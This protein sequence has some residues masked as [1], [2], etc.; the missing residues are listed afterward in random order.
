[1]PSV[2]APHRTSPSSPL[3]R[4][5]NGEF[6]FNEPEDATLFFRGLEENRQMQ[7]P[8][9]LFRSAL[10]NARETANGNDN[11]MDYETDPFRHISDDEDDNDDM[12][13]ETE[14]EM[15]TQAG[16]AA[17][18]SRGRLLDVHSPRVVLTQRRP[19][20]APPLLRQNTS[21]A[22]EDVTQPRP[23]PLLRQESDLRINMDM[24]VDVDM[25]VDSDDDVDL[26]F[27]I[28]LGQDRS[29][30]GATRGRTSWD[31]EEA[32]EGE[33]EGDEDGDEEDEEDKTETDLEAGNNTSLYPHMRSANIIT[34][35][36]GPLN[37]NF[38]RWL[39]DSSL[40]DL[41]TQSSGVPPPPPLARTATSST[42]SPAPRL[43]PRRRLLNRQ[44]ALRWQGHQHNH[45]HHPRRRHRDRV[46]DLRQEE[47]DPAVVVQAMMDEM[48][49]VLSER[50]DANGEIKEQQ[51]LA[52]STSSLGAETTENA[53][54]PRH[55]TDQNAQTKRVRDWAV[56][57]DL[58]GRLDRIA[59]SRDGARA[60]EAVGQDANGSGVHVMLDS[61]DACR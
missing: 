23:P 17:R 28:L 49:Q 16:N 5:L 48:E 26:G 56:C 18:T 10:I 37:P 21:Q 38:D 45:P 43:W 35:S 44:S 31:R 4:F 20:R 7:S 53:D 33:E 58:L 42:T 39:P 6:E 3:R 12:T 50:L 34:S 15:V 30:M 41:V 51:Q 47:M 27:E 46:R 13:R 29:P 9:D 1:M 32:D 60:D 61:G 19:P 54:G 24:D 11:G 59:V 14:T 55:N 52:G 22:Q 40:I 36:T 8:W 2:T 57:W 25:D